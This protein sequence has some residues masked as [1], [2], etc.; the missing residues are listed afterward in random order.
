MAVTATEPVASFGYDNEIGMGAVSHI[1]ENMPI[2]GGDCQGIRTKVLKFH[3]V[4]DTRF[5]IIFS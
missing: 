4:A 5:Q 2:S 1:G 3:A